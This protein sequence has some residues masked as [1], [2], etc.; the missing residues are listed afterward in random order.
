MLESKR[1]AIIFLTLS[2]LLAA[3]AGF[4]V[5]K[6]VRDM[7][8][9]LGQMIE[10]YVANTDIASRSLISPDQVTAKQIPKKFADQSYV[11][12]KASLQNQVTVV[13]LSAGDI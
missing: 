2:F 11:T 9:Q 6:K 5:L 1:R 12:D 13:P 3:A 4:L 8:E 7:N 10:I